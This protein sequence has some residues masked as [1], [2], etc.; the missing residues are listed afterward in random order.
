MNGLCKYPTTSENREYF[1][2]N[3]IGAPKVLL[4]GILLVCTQT[5]IPYSPTSNLDDL[6]GSYKFSRRKQDTIAGVNLAFELGGNKPVLIIHFLQ[7]GV[8][9]IICLA[10]RKVLE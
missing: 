1:S 9:Q 7:S 5:P 3:W 8:V 6:N 4:A 2:S 10:L